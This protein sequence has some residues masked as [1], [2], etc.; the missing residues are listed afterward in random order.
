MFWI[1]LF[2]FNGNLLIK[3]KKEYVANIIFQRIF[4]ARH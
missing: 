1:H 4:L 3:H 2:V